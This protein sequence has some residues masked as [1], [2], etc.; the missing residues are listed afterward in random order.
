MADGLPPVRMGPGA[1]LR[2]NAGEKPRDFKGTIKQLWRI[3]KDSRKGLRIVLLLSICSS[4]SAIFSPYIIGRAVSMIEANDPTSPIVSLPQRL[5][6]QGIWAFLLTPFAVLL[7]LYLTDWLVRFLQQ[8]MM[9]SISQR[10]I[11]AIRRSLFAHMK[12]LP[13]SFFDTHQHGELMS[14]LTND[15]DTISTSISESLAQLMIYAFTIVGVLTIMLSSNVLLTAVCCCSIVLVFALTKMITS[16]SRKLYKK[17]QEDLGKLN[18][19]VEES[20]SGAQIVKAFGQEAEM[21]AEFER[22]N[23]QFCDAA[24][25]AITLSGYLMPMMNVINNFSYLSL[26]IVAGILCATGQIS[27][28]VVTTFLL[29]SRQFTRPF[30]D[31]ANIYNNFQSAVAGAERVFEILQTE[32]EAPDGA[33]ALSLTDP[34]GEIVLKDVSFSYLPDKPIL[35]NINQTIR[36]GTRVAIVGETGAGKT[37]IINLM[38]RLYDV[39]QGAITLDGH[40]LREYKREDLRRAFGVVLQDTALFEGSLRENIIYG[41]PDA[42]EEEV[43]AAARACGADAFIRR[44]PN[45]YDT[46]IESGDELSQGERQLI[47]IARAVLVN[48]PILILDEATSSVDTL[49]ERRIKDAVLQLTQDRTC[50]MIAHRLSTI[51]ESDCILLLDR[52]R[53]LEQ[54]T[55]EELVRLGGKYAALYR[56]QTRQEQTAS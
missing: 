7:M 4:A 10:M 53:V 46:V 8:F 27:L 52:G 45:G 35:S 50:F 18:A 14:R 40:D 2:N 51:R 9:T 32:Q 19:Q 29:Y 41:K 48:A 38:T 3:T 23:A 22:T 54:G 55:H 17:Q 15:I 21:I 47:T 26:A 42:G 34:K 24:T 44:L 5:M 31:T 28:G 43:I 30:V 11:L 12:R 13:L 39:T 1:F 6:D 37:T 36:P 20:I 33:D 49:T 16:R 56:T 25:K